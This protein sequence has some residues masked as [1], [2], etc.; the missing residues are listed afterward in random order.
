MTEDDT[1]PK[2]SRIDFRVNKVLLDR[3]DRISKEVGISRSQLVRGILEI[4]IKKEWSLSSPQQR[5]N[6]IAFPTCQ[7][8][9]HSP[10]CD[11]FAPTNGN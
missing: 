3:L 7:S 9:H 2:T 8:C 6:V 5:K 4:E 11:W 10:E 1:K